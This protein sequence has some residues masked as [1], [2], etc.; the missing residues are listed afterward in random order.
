MFQCILQ[1]N[2]E[3]FENYKAMLKYLFNTTDKIKRIAKQAAEFN[4]IYELQIRSEQGI[5]Y[6][7]IKC[8]ISIICELSDLCKDEYMKIAHLINPIINK[9]LGIENE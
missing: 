7:L 3:K 8:H 9:E 6:I 1:V 5:Y 2:K 4:P